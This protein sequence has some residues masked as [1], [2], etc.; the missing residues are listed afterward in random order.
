MHELASNSLLSTSIY[1]MTVP[2]ST[3]DIT[4]NGMTIYH[5]SIHLLIPAKFRFHVKGW[6]TEEGSSRGVHNDRIGERLLCRAGAQTAVY[7]ILQA[8]PLLLPGD[9]YQL[10]ENWVNC[11][12]IWLYQWLQLTK[13]RRPMILLDCL[14]RSRMFAGMQ[15]VSAVNIG[16]FARAELG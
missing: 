8:W 15:N 12:W 10:L 1:N 4:A 11:V 9:Q 3:E 14:W 5:R 6:N 2:V 13:P 7:Q 16:Y